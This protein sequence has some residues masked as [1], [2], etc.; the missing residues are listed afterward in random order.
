MSKV[1]FISDIHLCDPNIAIN[2]RGFANVYD[3]DEAL[4]DCWNS[5]INKHDTVWCLGDVGRNKTRLEVLL[6]RLNGNKKLVMGNHDRYQTKWY[7]QYFYHLFGAV[8]YKEMLL[9]H[10]PIH[11]SEFYRFKLNVHGH[12]HHKDRCI[13][14]KRYFNVNVD[15]LDPI[16]KP[17]EFKVIQEY[18]EQN[19]IMPIE[20]CT[21]KNRGKIDE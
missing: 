13:D 16:F 17:I 12:I 4:I 8:R 19:G 20:H 5:S 9:T 21:I 2:F 11:P 10:V 6:P 14:D 1:Y 3:H 7:L 15:V 18:M